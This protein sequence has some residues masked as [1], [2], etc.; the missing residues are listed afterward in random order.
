MLKLDRNSL[1]TGEGSPFMKMSA[2]CDVV[3]TWQFAD[4][5]DGNLLSNKMKVNLHILGALMLNGFGEEVHDVDIV[6]V[7]NGA[8]RRQGLELMEQLAQP[9][10]LSYAVG[11]STILDL[12]TRATTVC[13]LADHETKLSPRNTTL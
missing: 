11:N 7:D 10:G 2:N 1:N 4:L 6:A 8:P 5:A 13:R 12:S 3:G 9:S